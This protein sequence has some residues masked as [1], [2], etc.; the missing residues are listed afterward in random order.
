[1]PKAELLIEDGILLKRFARPW[2]PSG[3]GWV[4]KG[5]TPDR[6]E[7]VQERALELRT[8]R[9]LDGYPIPA[10]LA[11][12]DAS[13]ENGKRLYALREPWPGWV[14]TNPR[15]DPEITVAYR[16]S[17]ID[18]NAELEAGAKPKPEEVHARWIPDGRYAL[19]RGRMVP[20]E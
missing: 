3:W 9:R 16:R 11:L 5:W 13:L 17:F 6:D 12:R 7:W 2:T 20:V 4:P 8:S 19:K 18:L 14:P 10:E 1:M 15:D